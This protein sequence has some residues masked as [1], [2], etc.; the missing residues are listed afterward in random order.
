MK[1]KKSKNLKLQFMKYTDEVSGVEKMKVMIPNSREN[2]IEVV[3]YYAIDGKLQSNKPFEIFPVGK[4]TWKS[5]K[6]FAKA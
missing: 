3:T 6:E 4:V 2:I 5:A 1:D